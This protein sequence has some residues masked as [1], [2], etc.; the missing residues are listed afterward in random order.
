MK[1][2]PADPAAVGLAREVARQFR[3]RVLDECTVRIEHCVGLLT[4]A[5]V[6][7]RPHAHCNAIGNLLLHLEGNVRQ[8]IVAG[9]EQQHDR[10]DR[11]A[12]FSADAGDARPKAELVAQLRRTATDAATIVDG[13]TAARL[14]EVVTFQGG[15]F[16]DTA[17]AGVLHVMEH[18]S[19]HAYQIY[20][21]TKQLLGRDL[22]FYDL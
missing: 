14:L 15:K 1:E 16:H 18:F 17:I 20:D 9:L 12:E 10:R 22:K 3:T 4:Q 6:W 7:Q 11:A 19:G 2:P 13:L 8:W 5:Q 21:R